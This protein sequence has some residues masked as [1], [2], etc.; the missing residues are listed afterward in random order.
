FVAVRDQA[1][2]AYFAYVSLFGIYMA[3]NTGFAFQYF[4]PDS[5]RWGN[6]VLPVLLCL[7]LIAA[8][9]FS[10]TILRARD[11]T[12]RLNQ[13]ARGLQVLALSA[14][15][16]VPL[17]EY[18]VLIQPVTLLILVSVVFMIALGVICMLAGSR[19]ARF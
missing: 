8:L 14:I 1:F 3:V 15:A 6:A 7:S 9:E 18:A 16:L 4:W 5:P 2:L 19:P 11:Y 10:T 13:V 12:R 17:V